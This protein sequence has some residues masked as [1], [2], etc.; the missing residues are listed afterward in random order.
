MGV[1]G[2]ERFGAGP[3]LKGGGVVPGGVRD[4]QRGLFV[5][6]ALQQVERL[7]AGHPGQ[8]AVTLSPDLNEV[9]LATGCDAKTVHG[10]EHGG[11]PEVE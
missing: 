6:G 3:G 11:T 7:E 8:A 4:E 1:S 9:G 10:N 5:A 2:A